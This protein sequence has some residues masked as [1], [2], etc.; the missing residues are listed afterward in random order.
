MKKK[1]LSIVLGL[2][3]CIGVVPSLTACGG[4]KA[5]V[6]ILLMGNNAE[7]EFYEKHF[8]EVGDEMG[9]SIKV[10]VEASSNYYDA[11]TAE[12][13]GGTTPDIFY[14]RPSDIRLQV[15]N[16]IIVGI[17]EYLTDEYKATLNSIHDTAIASYKYDKDAKK[18]GE[19]GVTYAIPKDLSVQQLGYNKYLLE[20]AEQRI[21]AETSVT[22]MPW[23]MDWAT[24]NYTW[25]QFKDMARI[26]S[27]V[28]GSGIYGCDIPDIE[29]LTWS[30]G[31]R[32]LSEDKKRV[33]IDSDP[34]KKAA[35]YQAELVA[36]GAASY[37][38]ATYQNFT[39]GK[40]GFYGLTNSFDIKNFDMSFPAL[41]HPTTWDV[42]PWPVDE[43]ADPTSWHG[44]I[45]SAGYAVSRKCKDK[46]RAVD[47]IMTLLENRTQRQLVEDKLQ[48]PL[49]KGMVQTFLED[50]KY[51]PADREVYINVIQGT[52]GYFSDDYDCYELSWQKPYTDYLER[53]W[54]GGHSLSAVQ[55]QNFVSIRNDAQQLYD[56]QN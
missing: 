31:G 43:G 11:L 34:F 36:T 17:D 3:L 24:E 40:V 7:T 47:V 23:E 13:N 35:V 41:E 44:K 38:G 6:S 51:S 50:D 37:T 30:F 27:E 25:A 9:I 5:D 15:G 14:V 49:L 45:T 42:M 2:M 21:K 52:N 18:F 12:I 22:K 20:Q 1:I 29:I 53:V 19:G 4:K 46:Q 28:G 10:T 39:T 16:N 48:L 8:K 55:N 32:I 54:T 33:N 56:L 26:V